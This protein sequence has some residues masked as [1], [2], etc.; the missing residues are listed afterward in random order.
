M[1]HRWRKLIPWVLLLILFIS[2]LF[3]SRYFQSPTGNT[4][5]P[6][7]LVPEHCL[8]NQIPCDIQVGTYNYTVKV[9]GEVSPLKPFSVILDGN[10]IEAATLSFSMRDMDMGV[11]RFIMN[12]TKDSSWETQ[13]MLPVCTASRNDWIAELIVKRTNQATVQLV[14]PFVTHK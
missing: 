5:L 3:L 11:N 7:I 6:A 12:N 10:D 8:F 9:T 2:G 13:A 4:E 1:N 14:Y